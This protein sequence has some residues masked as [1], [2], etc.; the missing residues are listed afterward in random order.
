M[1]LSSHPSSG[2]AL[3]K[4][5]SGF[6]GTREDEQRLG[7]SLASKARPRF[8][9]ISMFNSFLRPSSSVGS[10][11]P[12]REAKGELRDFFE[13]QAPLGESAEE[14]AENNLRDESA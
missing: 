4:G 2:A 5:S 10:L 12:Y 3:K 1:R 7:K 14:R 11:R 9:G 8:H 13:A 6:W